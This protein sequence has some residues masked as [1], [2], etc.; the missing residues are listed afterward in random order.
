MLVCGSTTNCCTQLINIAIHT[1]CEIKISKQHDFTILIE[2]VIQNIIFACVY[3]HTMCDNYYLKGCSCRLI[4]T[5][6]VST[7][8]DNTLK[9]LSINPKGGKE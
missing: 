8:K 3:V 2:I 4:I 1:D 6:R 7:S 9:M 5:L